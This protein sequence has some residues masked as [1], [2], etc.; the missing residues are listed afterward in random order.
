MPRILK[1]TPFAIDQD[2]KELFIKLKYAGI[3]PMVVLC[4]GLSLI[5][6]GRQK[7]PYLRVRDAADWHAKELRDSRGKSGNREVL[8][9]FRK[10][11]ADFARGLVTEETG[12]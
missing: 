8:E 7:T 5:Y 11:L 9:L 4:D 2:G 6:F 10:A 3:H 1:R 12:R